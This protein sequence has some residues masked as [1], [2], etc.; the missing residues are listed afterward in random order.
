M[1]LPDNM[2]DPPEGPADFTCHICGDT[3][4]FDDLEPRA[5]TQYEY[6]VCTKCW[7]EVEEDR[8]ID[9]QEEPEDLDDHWG[10]PRIEEPETII[11]PEKLGGDEMS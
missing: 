9:P 7:Q 6:A 10:R 2:L 8:E 11:P 4:P 5:R 3:K 1:S